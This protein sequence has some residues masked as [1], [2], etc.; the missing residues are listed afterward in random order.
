MR[1][2][3]AAATDI[4]R[5]REGNE[6]S[7]V[8]EAPLFAV[9]DGMGGH[10]GGEVASH[11]ALETLEVHFKHKRGTIVDQVREANRAVFERSLRDAEVAGMGTTLTALVTETARIRLAHV[12]DS[13]AYLLRGGRLRLLTQDHTL[14]HRMV[15]TGEITEEEAE[16]HPHRSILTRAL[17]TEPDVQVDESVLDVE[18]D[19]RILLCTDGLSG[20]VDDERVASILREEAEPRDA[21][22]RLIRTAN[23]AGGVDN[24]TVVVLDVELDPSDGGGGG[25]GAAGETAPGDGTGTRDAS[26]GGG[27]GRTPRRR[28][29]LVRRVLVWT[30]AAAIVVVITLVGLRA[31]LDRQWY[32]GVANGRVAVFRGVPSEVLGFRL[33]EVVVVTPIRAAEATQLGFYSDLSKGIT[34]ESRQAA[35]EIV[36]QIQADLGARQ[37]EGAAA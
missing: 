37:A 34:A 15:E 14:V 2:R 3:A 4:G 29:H 30:V 20:M 33:H 10:R 22:D 16:V 5:V 28:A 27:K 31:Y 17:G 32:V 25:S 35:D 12:G 8:V 11:L 23:D 13:R 18:D 24:I 36:R 21:A 6:D 9:A 26:P 7:F 19:D 1:I